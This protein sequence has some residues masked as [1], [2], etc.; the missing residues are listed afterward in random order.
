MR[1]KLV[2]SLLLA[3][4][5]VCGTAHGSVVGKIKGTITDAKTGEPLV[6]ATV[7]VQGT[8]L[9]A[10]ANQDGEYS[11]LNVPVGTYTVVVSAVGYGTV[12]VENVEVSADLAAYV[13]QALTSTVTELGKSIT[14]TAERPM[15]TPDKTTSISIVD[16]QQLQA[17][18]VQSFNEVVGIQNSVV[19]MNAGSFG[20]RQR[21]QRSASSDNYELN[22]RGGRPQEVAYYVDGFSQQDPLTGLSTTRINNNAIKEVS[23]TSGAFS[24]EYGYVSSGIVQVIT[25]SGTDQYRGNLEVSTDNVLKDNFDQN[26]YTFDLGGPIPGI[27]KLYFFGSGERRWLRDRT[28]SAKTKDMIQTVGTPFDLADLYGNDHRLPNNS[29][30]GWAYQGKI[31]YDISSN[32]RLSV[33]GNGNTTNWREYR[34]EWALSPDHGPRYLDEN[35]GINA[36][37]THTID[38][39]TFYN[40]SASYFIT[41]RTRGDATVFDNYDAYRR[42]FTNPEFEGDELFWTPDGEIVISEDSSIF[43]PAYYVS[44]LKSKSSYYGVKGDLTR[45]L[46]DHNTAKVGFDF[47]RHTL[48]RFQNLDATKVRTSSLINRYGY[49]SLGNESDAEGYRNSTKHPINLGAYVTDRIEWRGLIV[50]AGVRLDL[51]DYKAEGFADPIHPFGP[52]NDG[53][54]DPGDLTS[55][56]TYVRVSPRLGVAFP[57]SPVTQF[58]INYGKF[59]QRPNLAN[60]YVGLDF[61]EARVTAGS[62]YPFPSPLL[63]PEKTT[64]YEIGLTHQLGD[65]VAFDIDAYYKD[66]QDLTQIFHQYS[67]PKAYDIYANTDYGTIKGVDMALILKRTHNIRMD[68]RYTLSYASGT[69][70]YANTAYIINWQNPD[71][72]VKTTNPLDYDQRHSF[73]CV[74]EYR[75]GAKEGPKLGTSY[76]LENTSINFLLTAGSGTPYTPTLIYDEATEN[77]VTPHPV[78]KIDLKVERRIKVSGLEITPYI[79]VKNL[80]NTDNIIGVY[81]GT[82]KPLETGFL[83][84]D[85]GQTNIQNGIDNGDPYKEKYELKQYNPTNYSNPRMVFFGLRTSF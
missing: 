72:P 24:A 69:G 37:L 81:E 64:Q 67:I 45:Q 63:K 18:P 38:A 71:S 2:S 47:Q 44:F 66:V 58:R 43:V 34:Q 12:T 54:I 32:M 40:L 36:K 79:W 3:L 49:D 51:F 68:L 59:Y 28:P 57:I 33:S 9:G 65:N 48:R 39:K 13:D 26:Y 17:L 19:R 25:N 27:K 21:G 80:L 31:D 7:A 77:A 61:Y 76:P 30:S 41:K 60:L 55:V 73:N 83:R 46:G 70:S 85:V 82:G 15:V 1:L 42:P 23:V 8:A 62:Y 53:T 56:P 29:L 75:T 35:F 50:N 20:Q 16:R 22:L 6:G 14:V 52:T 84:T 4:L 5:V 10:K 74:V 78:D 11:I